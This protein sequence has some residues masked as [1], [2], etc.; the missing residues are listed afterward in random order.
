M[1]DYYEAKNTGQCSCN[2]DWIF[3]EEDPE[4]Y[5]CPS[6]GCI[7]VIKTEVWTDVEEYWILGKAMPEYAPIRKTT[8]TTTYYK[9]METYMAVVL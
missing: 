1:P 8:M 3:L 9:N 7:M 6:C 5:K 4:I 2:E